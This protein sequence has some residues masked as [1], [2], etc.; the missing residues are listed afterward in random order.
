MSLGLDCFLGGWANHEHVFG[1]D[2]MIFFFF[3]R[4]PCF[5]FFVLFFLCQIPRR[6][7]RLYVNEPSVASVLFAF[8]FYF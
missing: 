6:Y 2:I 3:L 8:C 1:S 7:S 5:L 4:L